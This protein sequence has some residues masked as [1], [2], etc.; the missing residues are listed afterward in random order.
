M[1]TR[2]AVLHTLDKQAP[3]A[4]S[5]PLKIEEIE[6]DAPG[7]GEVLVKMKAAGLCHSD[8]SVING[9]RPR[10]VPMALGHEASGQIM[11][12]GEGISDLKVGDM[13]VLVFVPSC[14]HCMPCRAQPMPLPLVAFVS[15][16]QCCPKYLSLFNCC[17]DMLP[18]P[19]CFFLIRIFRFGQLS[20]CHHC[21]LILV[22]ISHSV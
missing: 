5:K 2:A 17:V 7:P 13:V 9:V 16:G 14:G 10:P 15:S 8:L 19:S 20:E 11:Q 22:V 3:F 21:Q 18:L 1:K 12:V 4:E 6:L